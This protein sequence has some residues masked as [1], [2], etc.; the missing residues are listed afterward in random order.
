MHLITTIH[1]AQRNVIILRENSELGFGS[2]RRV[3]IWWGGLNSNGGLMLL[4]AYLL[5][6]HIDWR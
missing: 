2:R 1:Q 6:S 4:L 3:D 5:R